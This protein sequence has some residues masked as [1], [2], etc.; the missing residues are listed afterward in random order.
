MTTSVPPGKNGPYW[1]V[2]T[3]RGQTIRDYISDRDPVSGIVY[4]CLL[5]AFAAIPW[6]LARTGRTGA[7]A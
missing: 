5:I 3:L 4:V 7:A 1:V 6:A 2:L